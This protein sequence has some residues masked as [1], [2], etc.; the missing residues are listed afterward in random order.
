MVD[1]LTKST[2]EGH[3]DLILATSE[4]G[5]WELDASTGKAI[6]NRQHDRI[7]GHPE[8]KEDWSDEVFLSYVVDEDR[9]RVRSLLEASLQDGSPWQFET[10][11]RRLDG[12]LRWI[13]AKGMPKFDKAGTVSKL[14]GH[15]IDITD[16]KETE[17]R[18]RLISK[19]L[20]HRVANTFAIINSMI[21]HTAKKATSV[22]GFA[23]TL[24][25]R[26][27]ALTRANRMLVADE[28]QRSSLE[29]IVDMELA[30]FSGW[31]ERFEISGDA[32]VVFSGEASEALAMIFHELLTNA[33]K[34][35]ALSVPT[36]RV[37]IE[38]ARGQKNETHIQWTERNGPPIP[39][40]R[41]SGI[42]SSVLRNALR[43][44]GR[45]PLDYAEDGPRCE[46]VVFSC[47]LRKQPVEPFRAAAPAPAPVPDEADIFAGRQIM[48]VEDDPIIGMDIAEIF[49]S[50]GATVV[51][52]L[53]T[54]PTALDALEASFDVAVLDVNLGH[55]NTE[56]VAAQLRNR[57]IPF[58]IL[59][60][61]MDTSD[62]FGA[63]E[64]APIM[65]KPFGERD[66][67]R[68]LAAILPT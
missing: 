26:L 36:G 51:G 14:I 37:K 35:G 53:T 9:Q 23:D 48:V 2:G 1:F 47:Y 31:R 67:V 8:E 40:Q 3:L 65:S 16:I 15:V 57:S 21:R 19:E 42:G 62:L 24:M 38:I 63:Y 11:I 49:R 6:R 58:L 66:L 10:R 34:H 7:F 20:N 13:S 12:T 46:I 18:L 22:E 56:E 54:V 55:E 60:G 33:V 44:E 45:V 4:I 68:R 41:R 29:E 39:A 43:D 28:R 61:R 32:A 27:A 59:S 30:G 52:P 25:E 5:V 17:D 50:M 64:S